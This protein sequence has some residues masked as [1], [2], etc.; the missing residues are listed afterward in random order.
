PGVHAVTSALD[1]PDMSWYQE[2]RLFER[3]VRVVGDEVAAVAAESEEIAEDA[4]RLIEVE[5]QPLPC[6]ADLDAALRPDAP[7][8]HEGGNLAGEPQVYQ[9]GDPAAGF[10]AAEVV[11]EA[12]YRTQTAPH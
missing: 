2:G 9:R 11:V 4:L 6:V 10:R 12:T 8:V 5:Y 7:R 3:T 1:A